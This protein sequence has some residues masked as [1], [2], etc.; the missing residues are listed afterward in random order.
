MTKLT[1]RKI[2][3]AKDQND[4]ETWGGCRTANTLNPFDQGDV[5]STTIVVE[6][7]ENEGVQELLQDRWRE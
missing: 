2:R 6:K 4:Y 3:R 5:R 7:E 1:Y